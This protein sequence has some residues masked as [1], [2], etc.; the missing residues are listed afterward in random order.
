MPSK[1]RY[2]NAVDGI[3]FEINS[4]EVMGLVGETGS[5]KTTT[6]KLLALLDRPTAGKIM[7]EDTDLTQLT[8]KKNFRR[9]VQMIFQDPYD[10]LDPRS[11]IKGSIL[12]PIKVHKL[13]S[14]KTEEELV[15]SALESVGLSP[16]EEFV[17]RYPHELSGGQKQRAS[18]ARAVVLSPTFIVA[19]EPVSMLD[20]SARAGIMRLMLKLKN[21]IGV[22]YLFISHDLAAARYMCDKVAIMYYGKIVENGGF[23]EV[24]KN[25]CHPYTEL[26]LSAIPVAD[27]D[28]ERQRI[29]VQGEPPSLI[30]PPR[31]CRF[32]SQCIHRKT[33]CEETEP[34]MMEAR[35]NHF[36]MCHLMGKM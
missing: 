14:S 32:F 8:G 17:D 23:E 36:V 7:F 16:P 11:T 15:Y 33:F 20:V 18:I 9:K 24:I 28:C 22:T 19:D 27:P 1:P 12:E 30:N 13:A 31:G 3:D 21:E 25:P 4:G 6:G 10:S 26:L 5:G 34:S 29:N 35:K 2:V